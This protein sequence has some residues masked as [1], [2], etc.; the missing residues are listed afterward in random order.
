MGLLGKWFVRVEVDKGKATR[1]VRQFEADV[2]RSAKAVQRSTKQLGGESFNQLKRATMGFDNVAESL[3]DVGGKAGSLVGKITLVTLALQQGWRVG[4]SFGQAI[5]VNYAA[6]DGL[7]GSIKTHTKSVVDNIGD[8]ELALLRI[9]TLQNVDVNQGNLL[10]PIKAGSSLRGARMGMYM[11]D[12]GAELAKQ[13]RTEQEKLAD[14]MGTRLLQMDIEAA[15]VTNNTVR[16]RDLTLQM[17]ERQAYELKQQGFDETAIKYLTDRAKAVERLRA[18]EED[19]LPTSGGPGFLSAK[20]MTPQTDEEGRLAAAAQSNDF[21][22]AVASGARS[23]AGAN[24]TAART[25]L[26]KLSDEYRRNAETMVNVYRDATMAVEGLFTDVLYAGITGN[27][28]QID[29]AFKAT[30]KSIA[31]EISSFLAQKAVMKLFGMALGAGGG[32]VAAADGGVFKGGISTPMRAFA[33]GGVV[34][35]PTVGLVGEG[36]YNEAV[37]PLPD[38]NSIPV[39]MSGDREVVVRITNMLVNDPAAARVSSEE[40]INTVQTDILRGGPTY[41]AIR[42]RK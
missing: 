29:D 21:A 39:V 10:A 37:V 28:D 34:T 40:I 16:L 7:I 19:R 35:Q 14:V 23:F 32:F 25:T 18:A 13:F 30:L 4:R 31:R 27:L 17:I 33:S 41:R 1:D 11:A 20:L 42:S 12:P 2:D 38:G 9:A 22:A 36:R 8:I 3:G 24:L 6:W 5:G 15:Q 26:G